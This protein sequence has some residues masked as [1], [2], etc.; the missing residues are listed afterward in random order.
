MRSIRL[1]IR[2]P[3]RKPN[4]SEGVV[5]DPGWL[6][7][8]RARR[9]VLV[10]DMVDSVHLMQQYED[11]VIDRWRRFVS[12][13]VSEVLPALGGRMVKSLGDGM[14]LEFEVSR[15]AVEAAFEL[16]RRIAI[17]NDLHHPEQAI[18]L[19]QGAHAADVVVDTLD[20]FGQGVNLAARLAALGR[21]GELIVSDTVRDEMLPG[22]DADVEDLG[23]CYLKNLDQPQRAFRI[24]PALPLGH[25]GAAGGDE[26]AS[27]AVIP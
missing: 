27:V 24:G 10:V 22:V 11:S 7:A 5:A 12:E 8:H 1:M 15:N 14:L 4:M 20:I 2:I 21:G 16:N 13:V 19:R 25:S 18:R 3:N 6:D 23:L 17:Y 9:A 26:R